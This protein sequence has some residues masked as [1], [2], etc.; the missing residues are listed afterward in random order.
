MKYVIDVF[1]IAWFCLLLWGM[2]PVRPFSSLNSEYLS[3]KT[4][5][6]MR[7]FFAL[8]IVLNHVSKNTTDGFIL[9]GFHDI[10]FLFVGV[11]FF[12]SGYGLMKS[13]M[14]SADYKK[15]FPARRIPPI[16]VTYLIINVLY[17]ILFEMTGRDIGLKDYELMF[18]EGYPVALYSWYI[19]T[20]LI[21]YFVFWLLMELC[22]SHYMMIIIGACLW[23]FLYF[24]FCRNM[25]YGMWW[26]NSGHLLM[27][28]M[29]WALFEAKILDVIRKHYLLLVILNWGLFAFSYW[30][31]YYSLLNRHKPEYSMSV[32]MQML[33][34]LFFV[35]GIVLFLL[36]FTV[37]N[38]ILGFLGKISLEL[39]LV[40]GLCMQ[41]FLKDN[42]PGIQSEAVNTL[43]VI[44]GT[45]ALGAAL[46]YLL[47][48]PTKRY[49]SWI[50]KKTVQTGNLA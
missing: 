29:F 3:L 45:I 44:A 46:H 15:H 14:A 43:L 2:K 18:K 11:F 38:P 42:I 20:I 30:Y 33:C 16:L 22:G 39:Y 24:R 26:Y 48:G 5:N 17:C 49:K 10:G 31:E 23:Y 47:A 25:K 8:A 9:R 36:K 13:Y 27:V 28:G 41:F 40:Q 4:G 1:P 37:G 7:G 35:L 19:I 12:Y 50:D 6:Y 21:F 32:I 34:V